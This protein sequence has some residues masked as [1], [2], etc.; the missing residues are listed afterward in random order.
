MD[1]VD[2][3]YERLMYLQDQIRAFSAS[4]RCRVVCTS[5]RKNTDVLSMFRDIASRAADYKESH[6]T[7]NIAHLELV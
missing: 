6:E 3:D 4:S 7:G 2:E 1:I 5:A